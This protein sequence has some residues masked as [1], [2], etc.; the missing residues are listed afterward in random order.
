MNWISATLLPLCLLAC[1]ACGAPASES[2]RSE[3]TYS[4]HYEIS[5]QPESG[6]VQVEMQLQQPRGL[7][8]EL[9]FRLDDRISALDGDGQLRRDG[10]RLH[11]LPGND[12]G[13]LR[14]QV[15]V[16]H[17]RGK[18]GFDAL[19]LSDWGIF[20]AE[21]VIPR[22]ATRT[23]KGARSRTTLGFDLPPGWS[24]ISEYSHAEQPIVVERPGRRFSQPTGWVAM[25][26]LGV[27][28]E[29]IA[30]S[31]VAVAGPTGHDVRRMDMLALLNW[32]L[33]EVAALLGSVPE[34]LT[35]VSADDPMWRGGLS[36]PQSIFLHADRPLIS[37][38]ATST[39]VHEIMHVAL[40]FDTPDVHDWIA[41]GLAEYYSLEL[42]HRAA[43]ISTRRYRR[44][45]EDQEQW[46]TTAKELCGKSSKGPTTA[47]AAT[48]FRQLDAELQKATRGKAGL[49]AVVA[50]LN[51]AGNDI[52]LHEL[53]AAV[54][55][56]T[57]G[58]S[59]V[60]NTDNLPGCRNMDD[61][62]KN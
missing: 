46:A 44:A 22:A 42:L 48:L 1:A 23:L 26:R 33:P 12:G 62:A 2:G 39:L 7:L 27:R 4:L 31:R 14:W 8:R 28:R 18:S 19:L 13:R 15:A 10:T 45:I 52:G 53:R 5:P 49:D 30:G 51:A 58:N 40:T 54:R 36:G 41:E 25:G 56:R 20:R 16:E 57:N 50:D 17:R 55:S 59:E 60:L 38:N 61:P 32:T 37:E 6:L 47:L 43:A 24:V 9:S 11:W 29:V 21:D 34:R 35:I 3:L